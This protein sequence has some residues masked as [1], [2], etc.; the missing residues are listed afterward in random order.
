MLVDFTKPNI[1][2]ESKFGAIQNRIEIYSIYTYAG[3][4]IA[5]IDDA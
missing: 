3:E 1:V 2:I 4:L 5:F